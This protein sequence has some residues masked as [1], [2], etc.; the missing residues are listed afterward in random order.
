MT[1]RAGF[2]IIETMLAVV[3]VSIMSLIAF[4]KIRSSMIKADLRGARTRVVNM[5]SAARI[6]AMQGNRT[7]SLK[8]NGNVAVVTA[9]PRRNLPKG[10]NTLDTIGTTIN[11]S[12]VYGAAVTLSGGASHVDYD[13]RGVASGFGGAT[14]I[15]LT[16]SGYTQSVAVDMLGR[17]I[18]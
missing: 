5:L 17:V 2:T 3:I 7:A 11:L 8:F 18:K 6:T 12:T 9:S 15:T 13:P 1:R 4:P 10:A 16:R 14:T